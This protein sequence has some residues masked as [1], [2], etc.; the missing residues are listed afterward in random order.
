MARAGESGQGAIEKRMGEGGVKEA[1]GVVKV[2][3][4][5]EGRRERCEG[6]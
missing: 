6:T 5:D 1:L 2:R 4:N 3:R